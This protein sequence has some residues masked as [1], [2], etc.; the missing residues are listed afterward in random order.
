[1]A[2]LVM[3]TGATLSVIIDSPPIYSGIVYTKTLL[4]VQYERGNDTT[5]NTPSTGGVVKHIF[6]PGFNV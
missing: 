3:T 5:V 1:M 4:Q 6:N 2:A